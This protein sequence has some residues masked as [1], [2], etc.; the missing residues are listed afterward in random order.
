MNIDK[1]SEK[2]QKLIQSAQSLAQGSEHQFFTPVHVL[3]ALF[4]ERDSVARH[5]MD[6][7]GANSAAVPLALDD[8]LM[9]LPKVSGISQIYMHNDTAKLFTEAEAA[10]AKAGDAFVTAD[11]VFIAALST[12]EGAALLKATGATL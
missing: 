11:R 8:M 1:Y 10:A 9:K 2:T 12:P 3:K 4:D 6:M 5:L 7:V